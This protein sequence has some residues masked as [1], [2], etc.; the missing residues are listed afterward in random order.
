MWQ[1]IQYVGT[2]VALVAFVVAVAA[3]LV[4]ARLTVAQR[5]IASAPEEQRAQLVERALQTY[6]LAGDRDNLTREQKFALLCR[7]IDKRAERFRITTIT[8]IIV[9]IIVSGTVIAVSFVPATHGATKEADNPRIVEQ[10]DEQISRRLLTFKSSVG[11]NQ[12][13]LYHAVRNLLKSEDGDKHLCSLL[14]E[15]A[16]RVPIS[17]KGPIEL[18]HKMC[19]GLEARLLEIEHQHVEEAEMP[20]GAVLEGSGLMFEIV[21]KFN[22]KRW[23]YPFSPPDSPGNIEISLFNMSAGPLVRK[24]IA[25][26]SIAEIRALIDE[27][28]PNYRTWASQVGENRRPSGCFVDSE[29]A[30]QT[31][32]VDDDAPKIIVARMTEQLTRNRKLIRCAG[33]SA[34][35]EI[36]GQN[37]KKSEGLKLVIENPQTGGCLAL[38]WR[39]EPLPPQEIR[40]EEE[41]AKANPM[42]SI[43]ILRRQ[44]DSFKKIRCGG[45]IFSNADNVFPVLAPVRAAAK[46]KE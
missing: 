33:I 21:E 27:L 16:Q 3:T 34:V 10:L 7:E 38:L 28:G 39:L 11:G 45:S 1:A 25:N 30:L 13:A 2:P 29:G 37:G 4:R 6:T 20:V 12:Q 5:M 23:G 36:D 40:E 8:S 15:L 32:S 19:T 35:I 46:R 14:V 18:A 17:E 43:P 41:H 42:F 22:L 24:K 9:A 26:D 31:L 44:I